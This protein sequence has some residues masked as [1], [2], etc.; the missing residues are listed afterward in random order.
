MKKL[1]I[2][3]LLFTGIIYSQQLSKEDST[4]VADIQYKYSQIMKDYQSTDSLQIKRQGIMQFLQSEYAEIIKKYK[5]KEDA[6]KE[7]K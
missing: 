2:I 5:K 1:I 4:R 6:K 3:F 7:G